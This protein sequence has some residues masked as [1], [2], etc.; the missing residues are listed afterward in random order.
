M[1][2]R[3]FLEI[4]LLLLCH[5]RSNAMIKE[6]K[7]CYHQGRNKSSKNICRRNPS[8][9][10]QHKLKSIFSTTIEKCTTQGA[11]DVQFF[12][13]NLAEKNLQ[14]K[15]ET[16]ILVLFQYLI[17]FAN[18]TEQQILLVK[19]FHKYSLQNKFQK[20]LII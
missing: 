2:C 17:L 18:Q 7:P 13:E 1:I 16:K 8:H 15:H 9:V 20:N 5:P 11:F 6:V 12:F 3:R 19:L 10:L 14:I 4:K